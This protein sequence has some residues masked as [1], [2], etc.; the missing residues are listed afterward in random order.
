MNIELQEDFKRRGKAGLYARYM[1]W[2]EANFRDAGKRAMGRIVNEGFAWNEQ[3]Q[4]W[5]KVGDLTG[6]VVKL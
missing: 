3:S 2:P 5:Q 6:E 1:G 4:D